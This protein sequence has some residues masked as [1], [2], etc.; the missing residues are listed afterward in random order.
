M[1]SE[2]ERSSTG[3]PS[4]WSATN[5]IVAGGLGGLSG[6]IIARWVYNMKTGSTAT[7]SEQLSGAKSGSSKKMSRGAA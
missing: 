4:G 7:V 1:S 6:F 3:K 5:T 2:Y